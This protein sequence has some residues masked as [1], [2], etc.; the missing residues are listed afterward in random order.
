VVVDVSRHVDAVVVRVLDLVKE[1]LV[2]RVV[3]AHRAVVADR[4][5]H[6]PA[7]PAHRGARG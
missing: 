2:E 4:H 3:H 6:I 7:R 5:Q 1:L